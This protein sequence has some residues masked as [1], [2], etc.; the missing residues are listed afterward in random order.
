MP[1]E[2]RGVAESV[3]ITGDNWPVTPESIFT[4]LKKNANTMF[5]IQWGFL[6]KVTIN[7]LGQ[8]DLKW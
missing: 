3:G 6:F 2:G 5:S 4:L 1:A 8:T 7:E